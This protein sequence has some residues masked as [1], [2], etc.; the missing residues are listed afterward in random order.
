MRS[1]G[2]LI[3]SSLS[4][5]QFPLTAFRI[6]QVFFF[7]AYRTLLLARLA[8]VYR[9]T[10]S[11][12][13]AYDDA[14]NEGCSRSR[15]CAR[16]RHVRGGSGGVLERRRLRGSVSFCDQAFKLVSQRES[17]ARELGPSQSQE[18]VGNE[19]DQ[20][21]D[22]NDNDGDGSGRAVKRHFS[23][24][25]RYSVVSRR[26]RASSR[27]E[28][29]S[30]NA[31]TGHGPP[32]A[33]GHPTGRHAAT[34]RP[35]GKEVDAK[36][37]ELEQ[38]QLSALDASSGKR[39]HDVVDATS[40]ELLEQ[41]ELSVLGAS[42][43]KRPHDVA[44]SPLGAIMHGGNGQHAPSQDKKSGVLEPSLEP[45]E[46]GV[47][48][49]S[50]RPAKAGGRIGTLVELK[51][52]L[53]QLCGAVWLSLGRHQTERAYQLAL[54]MELV[55][56]GVTVKTEA[57]IPTAQYRGEY[58]AWRRLDLLLRVADGSMAVIEVKAVKTIITAKAGHRGEGASNNSSSSSGGSIKR[59]SRKYGSRHRYY[60]NARRSSEYSYAS[61]IKHYL[62][63]S[64]ISH[65]FLVNFPRDAGFP[66]P[67]RHRREDGVRAAVFR[68]EPLCG[69][70]TPLND[71]PR[72]SSP[73]TINRWRQ[74]DGGAGSDNSDGTSD[75]SGPQVWYFHRESR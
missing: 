65:G 54:C 19:N 72:H 50:G 61:Q 22:D 69:A 40:D 71:A 45:P 2:E 68:Q 64:G 13:R 29:R 58:V 34:A 66:P 11:P 30:G 31:K 39:P 53:G 38:E 62:D 48:T 37:A 74:G 5:I 60:Y 75:D 42:S 46:G 59:G 73:A 1:L 56:R 43:G 4:G 49:R 14:D 35:E 33:P 44:S 57:E 28:H 3:F 52:E 63:I 26:E 32:R 67:R 8:Y 12:L 25:Q 51:Q 24:K 70:I 21:P 16:P 17:D 6:H 23:Q 36:G 10:P 15:P 41:E 20:Q 55:R 18:E 9:V 27:Q 7:S 47:A